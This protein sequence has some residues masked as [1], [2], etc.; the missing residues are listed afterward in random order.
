MELYKI[1]CGNFKLDGGAM[2]GVVPKIIWNEKYP[3]DENNLCTWSLRALLV[4]T[5]NR[6]VLIDCGCGEKQDNKFFRHYHMDLRHTLKSSLKEAGVK[7]EEITDHVLTHLHFDHGGGAVEYN[8]DKTELQ[9]TFPNATHWIGKAQWEL[10]NNPNDREKASFLPENFVPIKEFGKLILVEKNMEIFPD[11]E[12]RI[13]NGHT[14][15][16]I[17]PFI[18]NNGKTIVYMGDLLPSTAHIPMPYVMS[19]DARPMLTMDEKKTFFKEA[20]ENEYTLFF[21]HDY[22]NECCTLQDTMKGVRLKKT[23]PLEKFMDN[24]TPQL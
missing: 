11:F 17:I 14:E 7:P 13:F 5:E 23:F 2:F 20:V 15:G 19:Y 1:E 4:I 18:K 24:K 6:K 3:A 16:Q 9:L 21:E 10:A 22:Y 12:V 8:E